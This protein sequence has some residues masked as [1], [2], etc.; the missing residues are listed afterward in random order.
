MANRMVI[1]PF[2]AY[3]GMSN[4][5]R[6]LH[7]S[8][9]NAL[10]D[11]HKELADILSNESLKDDEKL[12]RYDQVIKRIIHLIGIKKET[13]LESKITSTISALLPKQPQAK[14]ENPARLHNP[15][16][17]IRKYRIKKV[18]KK[19]LKEESV[20]GN[21]QDE[22]QIAEL[23]EAA[24]EAAPVAVASKETPKRD[25]KS[26][27]LKENEKKLIEYINKNPTKFG[28]KDQRILKDSGSPYK[29]SSVEMIVRR[30][31]SEKRTGQTKPS[32]YQ[33]LYNLIQKDPI[34][35]EFIKSP[36]KG[37]GISCPFKPTLWSGF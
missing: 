36:Q 33:Q 9:D 17:I 18:T 19:D 20:L 15:A 8:E 25:T 6:V 3:Q 35:L 12:A 34:A 14:E 5:D 11:L 21:D 23:P 32:G 27:L 30:M 26:L 7:S 4:Q 28:I 13:G 29:N 10:I 2:D 37:K 1:M 22:N 31:M 16:K 24:T